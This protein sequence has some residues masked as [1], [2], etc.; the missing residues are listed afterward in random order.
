MSTGSS[1]SPDAN[2]PSTAHRV[3][4]IISRVVATRAGL[5][6]VV[7]VVLGRRRHG[8]CCGRIGKD[9]LS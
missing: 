6:F 7:A 1:E 9:V 5:F 4:V 2:P 8:C 3:R